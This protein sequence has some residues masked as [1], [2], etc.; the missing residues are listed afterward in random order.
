[1]GPRFRSREVLGAG[2]KRD[3]KKRK[4]GTRAQRDMAQGYATGSMA[5]SQTST[6]G[7][8]RVVQKVKMKRRKESAKLPY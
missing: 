3:A 6:D 4:V 8:A 1:L 7:N 2:K 5:S